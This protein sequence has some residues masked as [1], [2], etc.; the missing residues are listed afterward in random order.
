M[1]RRP[2]LSLPQTVPEVERYHHQKMGI[3]PFAL[4][5]LFD[6]SDNDL[7]QLC[8]ACE[9]PYEDEG[10]VR[11]APRSKFT[12]EPLQAIVDYH[13]ELGRSG[14]YHPTYFIVAVHQDWKSKGVIVVT[15][16]D[17]ELECRPDLLWTQAEESGILLVNLH[18]AN[19]DWYEAK[20]ESMVDPGD[21]GNEGSGNHSHKDPDS[22]QD[23]EKYGDPP[24]VG[25]HIAVYVGVGV[26]TNALLKAIEPAAQIKT[27]QKFVCEILHLYSSNITVDAARYHQYHTTE[28]STVHK[29]MFLVA[30]NPNFAEYGVNLVELIWDGK[31]AN[32][33]RRNLIDTGSSAPIKVLRVDTS[34]AVGNWSAIPLLCTIADKGGYDK[35]EPK[36]VLIGTYSVPYADCDIKLAMAVDPLWDRRGHSQERV[37]LG[38]SLDV[39]KLDNNSQLWHL[40]VSSHLS[41]CR[42]MRFTP[43]LCR[44]YLIYGDSEDLQSGVMLVRLD[45][46]GDLKERDNLINDCESRISFLR[47]HPSEVHRRVTALQKGKSNWNGNAIR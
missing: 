6:M 17:D 35:W 41:L 3:L 47:C 20:E 31:A 26:D 13:L 22:S 27:P 32:R 21:Y 2:D 23:G 10:T 7:T 45:W 9:S 44:N 14:E 24:P 30:D 1:A 36:H 33:S 15:L 11:R 8:V 19:T 40:L 12:E 37:A 28:H 34:S 43:N 39:S 46:N 5:T 25:F 18:M 29:R 4:Y 38:G 16:D 42:Q